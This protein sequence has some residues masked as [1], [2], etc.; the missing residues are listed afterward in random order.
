MVRATSGSAPSPS[1][2]PSSSSSEATASDAHA[3]GTAAAINGGR[4]E[5]GSAPDEA[6]VAALTI[7]M[8][9]SKDLRVVTVGRG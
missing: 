5:E 4:G 7:D 8:I 6:A 9:I 2:L 3:S 1:C